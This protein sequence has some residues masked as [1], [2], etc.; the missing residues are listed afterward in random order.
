M[1]TLRRRHPARFADLLGHKLVRRRAA[2]VVKRRTAACWMQA[3]VESRVAR[4][5]GRRAWS[6]CEIREVAELQGVDS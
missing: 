2:V 3:I 1:L 6:R 4:R 5:A